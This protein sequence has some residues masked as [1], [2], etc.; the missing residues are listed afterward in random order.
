VN[1][2]LQSLTSKKP[3]SHLILFEDKGSKN[4]VFKNTKGSEQHLNLEIKD[5]VLII[6]KGSGDL[7]E[8]HYSALRKEGF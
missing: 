1:L 5:D 4:T 7:S 6:I 3:A 8:K 2:L